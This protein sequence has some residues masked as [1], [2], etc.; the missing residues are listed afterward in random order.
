MPAGC[1]RFVLQ[2]SVCGLHWVRYDAMV[3]LEN[4]MEVVELS[5]SKAIA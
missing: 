4:W 2:D 1:L 5:V 3:V